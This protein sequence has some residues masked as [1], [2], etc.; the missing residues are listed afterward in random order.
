MAITGS[1]FDTQSVS[2]NTLTPFTVTFPQA[3]LT[4]VAIFHDCT[5]IQI[6]LDPSR[7]A[8]LPNAGSGQATYPARVSEIARR[9]HYTINGTTIAYSVYSGAT[10]TDTVFYY[11][12]ALTDSV[13][14]ESMA[15]V[16]ALSTLSSGSGT[17]TLTFPSGGLTMTGFTVCMGGAAAS[18]ALRVQFNTSPGQVFDAYVTARLVTTA[19][20][21]SSDILPVALPVSQTVALTITLGVGAD[22]VAVVAYYTGTPGK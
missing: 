12:T 9:V 20:G 5:F 1:V 7:N 13:P 14:L 19:N 3:G 8:V 2:A 18:L 11:G 22:K 4:I 15:G 17:A 6:P 10:T 16:V 21:S